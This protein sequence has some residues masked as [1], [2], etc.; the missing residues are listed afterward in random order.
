MTV[1][2]HFHLFFI[3]S[4]S[5][6][7]SLNLND[8]R[9]IQRR[10]HQLFSI[11]LQVYFPR[12]AVALPKWL[13]PRP[14]TER[15]VRYERSSDADRYDQVPFLYIESISNSFNGLWLRFHKG[16][17]NEERTEVGIIKVPSMTTARAKVV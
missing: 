17:D 4:L 2:G 7:I 12:R 9:C 8:Y 14:P 1:C 11:R 13:V 5:D 15:N 3:E 10:L 16:I 6:D